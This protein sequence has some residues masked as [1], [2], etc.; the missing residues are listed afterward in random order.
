MPAEPPPTPWEF[1]SAESADPQGIVGIG[2]DLE[3]GTVLAAYR[4]GIFPMPVDG[5]L[6]WWSPDP[7][8]VLP[9]ASFRI[10]TSLSKSIRRYRTTVDRAFS[11]VI[12]GCSSPERPGGWITP[13]IVEAY[14]RLHELGWAHSIEVWKQDELVGGLYGIAIGGFFAGE[15]MFHRQRDASKVALARLVGEL[16]PEGLLDVQWQTDHLASL[17]TIEIRREDYLQRLDRSLHL[18]LAPPFA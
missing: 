11:E 10:S 12:A 3:P 14:E 1:P 17:G 7:R 15:S 8:A 2:A 4:S 6:A 9:L 16:H 5:V 18:P 13:E